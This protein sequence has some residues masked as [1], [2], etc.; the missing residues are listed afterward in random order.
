MVSAFQNAINF[1]FWP[2]GCWENI[3]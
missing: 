3:T 2:I 1:K